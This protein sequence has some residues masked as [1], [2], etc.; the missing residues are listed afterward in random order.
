[1][2]N[3]SRARR[4]E[5]EKVVGGGGGG[6]ANGSVGLS[7]IEKKKK[8]LSPPLQA[9]GT[10]AE[11]PSLPFLL[12]LLSSSAAAA[13]SLAASTTGA[14]LST[15]EHFSGS[16]RTALASK[17]TAALAFPRWS[18]RRAHACARGAVAEGGPPRLRVRP[19]WRTAA[20]GEGGR[21]LP[22]L[23]PPP[24]SVSSPR[25]SLSLVARFSACAQLTQALE[26]CGWRQTTRSK[27]AKA[28]S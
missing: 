5:T 26:F 6:N 16:S 28:R 23:L 17:A 15:G 12:L 27:T 1:M 22:P 13:A 10:A 3:Q 20:A 18:S 2:K 4:K 8:N 25:P 14:H 24:L 19:A 11:P 9:R 7:G 21:R